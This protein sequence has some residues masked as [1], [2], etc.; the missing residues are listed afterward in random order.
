[1]LG[2]SSM[3]LQITGSAVIHFYQSVLRHTL[4]ESKLYFLLGRKPQTSNRT[5]LAHLRRK[6]LLV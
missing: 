6:S 1:M 5:H 4:L 3:T 2:V